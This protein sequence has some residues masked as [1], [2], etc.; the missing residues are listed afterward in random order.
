MNTLEEYDRNIMVC[1]DCGKVLGVDFE[2][3][4]KPLA[5]DCYCCIDCYNKSIK[6]E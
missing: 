1:G 5:L 4:K 2:G 6:N 3:K